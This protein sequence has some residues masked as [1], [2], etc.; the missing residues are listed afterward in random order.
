MKKPV[1]TGSAVAIVTPF[2]ED[3][4]DFDKLGELVDYQ[5][6]NGTS[7]IVVCGTTG[8]ASTQSIPEHLA[9]VEY[10]IKKA[11]GRVQVIAGTGSNDTSHALMMSQN[12]E[13]SGA[14][15]LLLVTPYYNKTTQHGLVKHFTYVADRVNIPIILYNVPSRTGMSFTAETYRELSKHPNINGVKE[16]SG[17]F[18]LACHTRAICPEDFYVWS[19]N[20]D[21]VVPL[22][23]LGALGVISVAANVIPRQMADMTEAYLNGDVKTALAIQAKYFDLCDKLFVEVNPVPVKTAMNLL[24]WNVGQLRMPLTDMLPANVDKLRKALTDAGLTVKE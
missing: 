6:D 10:V 19:G 17:N 24:G 11:A 1:F 20:D 23:S 7:A 14:D 21:Q 16:A 15:A 22:M 3:F 13:K 9:T 8:E 18:T 4:I 2:T 12:A 5:I